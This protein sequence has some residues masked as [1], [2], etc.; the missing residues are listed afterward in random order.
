MLFFILQYALTLDQNNG[1]ISMYDGK[2]MEDQVG[3][4]SVN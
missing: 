1:V 2:S 4:Q 3:D